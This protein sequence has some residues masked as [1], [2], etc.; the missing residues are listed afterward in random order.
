MNFSISNKAAD[1]YKNELDLN[2]G[3][4]IRFYVRYGGHSPIQKGFSL[5]ISPDSPSNTSIKV[6]EAGITFFIENDDLW[7]F[8]NHDLEIDL[9]E[10]MNEPEFIYH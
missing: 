2:T 10:K 9:N 6:E 4:K 1:W 7:F 5:G 8:D 3:D